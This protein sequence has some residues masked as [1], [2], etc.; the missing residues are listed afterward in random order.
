MSWAETLK[1]CPMLLFL[2]EVGV[3][4]VTKLTT[5]RTNAL[6]WQ[7]NSLFEYHDVYMYAHFIFFL[8]WNNL[9][10][11]SYTSWEGQKKPPLISP[12]S[13]S[14]SLSTLYFPNICRHEGSKAS[15]YSST[16]N[17]YRSYYNI[18]AQSDCNVNN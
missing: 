5:H 2:I 3:S 15:G 16:L 13:C 6:I 10:A 12:S 4:Q 17:L 1:R 11:I 18:G 9:R 7:I 8:V 14:L